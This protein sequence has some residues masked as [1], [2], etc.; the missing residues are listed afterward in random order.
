MAF[1]GIDLGTT[2][3]VVSTL[4]SNGI[5]QTVPNAEGDLTTPSV[6]LYESNGEIVV[7]REAKVAAMAIPESVAVD[8]KRYMG[9][10]LYPKPVGGQSRSPVEISTE[11][12]KKLKIDAEAK[13]GPVKGCVITVPAYF[14]EGRRHATA[15]AAEGAGLKVL[16]VINEPTAAALSYAYKHLVDT[17]G[18]SPGKSALESELSKEKTVLV[19]DLGGGTFDVTLLRINGPDF[20]VLATDG[21][22]QLGGRDWDRTLGD[23]LAEQFVKEYGEDPRSD[24]ISVEALLRTAEEIK[25]NLSSRLKS[26]FVLNHAGHRL[27][28]SVSRKEFEETTR[29]LLYRTERRVA[30]ALKAASIDWPQVD[31]VLTTGGSTR[32]PQVRELLARLWGKQPNTTLSP[33]EA[34]AAG[35]AIHAATHILQAESQDTQLDGG[36]ISRLTHGVKNVIRAIRTT[37][38]NAH[39]FGVVVSSRTGKR[40][41]AQL[42]P[43]NSPLPTRVTQTFGTVTAD[44]RRVTVEIVEGESADVSHC[45][46]IGTCQIDS[47]PAGLPRNSPIQ[48]TFSYDNGGRLS[49]KAHNPISDRWSSVTIDRK[50]G[51][52]KKVISKK[53]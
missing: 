49:V 52:G 24:S 13:L 1:I 47:L 23:V 31:E 19:Y 48:V 36:L 18:L 16:D 37:N 22:I 10:E 33:D 3:S 40:K 45:M 5:P 6:V 8:V 12:L 15:K 28:G 39:S 14:D 9:D 50:V 29:P 34:V 27:M 2:Y 42:I 20:R 26:Q 21:D 53:I 35:A 46:P 51:V 30:R 4:D 44:Q 7:G 25:L 41:V 17:G 32:M 43:R 38:V 11:I